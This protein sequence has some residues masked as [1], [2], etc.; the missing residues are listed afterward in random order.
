MRDTKQRGT[1]VLYGS[2]GAVVHVLKET[3]AMTLPVT[4]DPTCQRQDCYTGAET[5]LISMYMLEHLQSPQG[6]IN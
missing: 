2:C 4:V 6:K 1:V 5:E 3:F